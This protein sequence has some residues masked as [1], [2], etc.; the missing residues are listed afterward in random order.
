M[1][2]KRGPVEL[3]EVE[4]AIPYQT[5]ERYVHATDDGLRRAVEAAETEGRKAQN[6]YSADEVIPNL[7]HLKI[8]GKRRRL[9]FSAKS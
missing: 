9:P 4:H 5:T 3:V 7:A 6:E 8:A 1:L 2:H